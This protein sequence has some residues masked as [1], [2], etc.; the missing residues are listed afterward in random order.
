MRIGWVGGL[1][2]SKAP[3]LKGPS[4]LGIAMADLASEQLVREC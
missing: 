3:S 1:D 4:G 2:R